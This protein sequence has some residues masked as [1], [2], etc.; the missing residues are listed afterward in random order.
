MLRVT[1]ELLH[2]GRE[3]GRHV[4][5]TADIARVRGGALADYSVTLTDAAVGEVGEAVRVNG[6]PRR[7]SSALDLVA[8]CLVAAL[9][10]GREELPPRPTIPEAIIRVNDAGYCYVR[11]DEI[12]E[13][14]RTYFDKS[15]AGSSIPDHGCAFAQDWFDFL[16]GQR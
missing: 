7:A 11:L 6:Y 12:P 10:Q 1:I 2:G 16:S 14:T 5:A 3:T 9:N 8:R 13:P 15:L 4:I